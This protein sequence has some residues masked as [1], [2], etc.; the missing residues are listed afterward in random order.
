MKDLRAI[1]AAPH[2]LPLAGH[3]VRLLRDPLAF[4]TSLPAHGDLVRI[5]LGPLTVVVLC[6]AELTRHVLTSDRVFDK[7]GPVYDRAREVAGNGL[8]TCPYSAHRRQRRLI[9]PAFHPARLHRYAETM[10]GCIDERTAAWHAG[11]V[12]EV[13]TEMMAIA[14]QAAAAAFFSHALPPAELGRI[15]DDVATLI[16]GMGRRMLMIP[17]LDRLPTPSNRSY[18]R[19]RAR[20]RDTLDQVVA[21]RLAEGTDRG[22]LLSALIAARDPEEGGGMSTAEI[23]DQTTA[24]FLAGTETT[25]ATVGWALDLLAQHPEIERRVHSEVDTVLG[26]AAATHADLPHLPLAE[27]VITETLRLRPPGWFITRVVSADT[28]LDGHL[29]P[30]GTTV[31]YSAYLIHHRPDLYDN[32]EAFDPDR[33]DPTRPQPPRHA[34]IPFA[35]GARKCIGDTFATTEATLALATITARWRLEHVPGHSARP[36]LAMTLRPR[37]LRMRAHPRAVPPAPGAR[38]AG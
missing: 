21:Q 20:L 16:N 1:P 25:A 36:A 27:R 10:T 28:E 37:D 22:D 15:L 8:P 4:L 30:A 14:S 23:G 18:L 33:W 12:L 35:A 2:A 11:Q 3:L 29:L 6:D 17:P 38:S 26:G 13:P 7:G 34:L 5:R 32:P 31:A 9:Q 19:A 24:F